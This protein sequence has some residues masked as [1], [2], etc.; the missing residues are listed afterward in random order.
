[1]FLL[2]IKIRFSEVYKS[3]RSSVWVIFHL[4]LTYIVLQF[5]TNGLFTA[6]KLNPQSF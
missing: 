3:K 1:M 4:T 2:E 5:C 6:D